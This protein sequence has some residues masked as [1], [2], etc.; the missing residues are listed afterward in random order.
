MTR[1]HRS[2]VT[3][4]V[5]LLILLVAAGTVDAANQ[6]PVIPTINEPATDGQVVNPFD[7]HMVTAPFADP[8]PGDTQGCTDWEIVLAS[9]LQPVWLKTCARNVSAFHI[10]LGD[11]A[12]QLPF[13]ELTSDTDYLLRVR[14]SDNLGAFSPWSQ[15]A[16]RTAAPPPPGS[17]DHKW[18]LRNPTT[19]SNSWLPAFTP[20][21]HRVRAE[22]GPSAR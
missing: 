13:T 14:H 10:H 18:V 21:E 4:A 15:R 22:P 16:F 20:G 12:F 7:V 2:L 8:D 17:P 1:T 9:T 5:V 11:G 19:R 6:P 3:Q